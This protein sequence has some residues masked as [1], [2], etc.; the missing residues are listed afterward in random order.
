VKKMKNTLI[1]TALI[2]GLISL[3]GYSFAAGTLDTET[4][5]TSVKVKSS[6][7]I[8]L[9]ETND[10]KIGDTGGLTSTRN[11]AKTYSAGYADYTPN[12]GETSWADTDGWTVETGSY[13]IPS[14]SNLNVECVYNSNSSTGYWYLNVTGSILTYSSYTIP[15]FNDEDT[16]GTFDGSAGNEYAYYGW[17]ASTDSSQNTGSTLYEHKNGTYMKPYYTTG[18]TDLAYKSAAGETGATIPIW[19]GM[20]IP[21]DQHEGGPYTSTVTYTMYN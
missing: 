8:T 4:V 20:K 7:G 6:Q 21:T 12:P 2:V 11:F 3:A 18:S 19:T 10:I 16:D 1:I 13:L 15:Y 5:S 14:Y 9:K 17:T